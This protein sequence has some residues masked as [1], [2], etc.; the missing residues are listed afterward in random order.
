MASNDALMEAQKREA[1]LAEAHHHLDHA[2]RA[3]V[4]KPG[5]HTGGV[6]G[7]FRLED[8]IGVGAMGEVYAAEHVER[9]L[10]A[11]R[12]SCCTATRSGARTWSVRFLREAAR[13]PAL[14]ASEPG[15]GARGRTAAGRR[16]VHGDGAAAGR[17]ARRRSCASRAAPAREV[18]A[19]ARAIGAGLAHAHENG[20][21]HRDLKPHNIFLHRG[22]DGVARWT[23]LD[24][25]ISKFDRL[26]RHADARVAG[27]HARV[28]VAGAGARPAVDHRSDLFALGSVLYRALTGQ[29]A[30]PGKEAPRIMFDVAYRMPKR[31]SDHE[32]TLPPDVDARV[33]DRLR[34]GPRPAL[35]VGRRPSCARFDAAPHVRARRSPARP[36]PRTAP[37]AT[38]GRLTPAIFRR[39]F[40]RPARA[41]RLG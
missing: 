34:Q 23:I 14:R 6:A 26:D 4:G 35:R 31:P 15:Q 12:S 5:R 9:R 29:P 30:F 22:S 10:A 21:V 13:L 16:A 20:V 25:G 41:C 2:M 36:R 27:R 28:H 32:V 24:F 38:L 3:A 40:R 8:V 33:R 1:L 39:R 11:R 7:D 19:I 37:R 17:D 18:V